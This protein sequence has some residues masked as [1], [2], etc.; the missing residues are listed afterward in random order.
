MAAEPKSDD[1][2]VV[3]GKIAMDDGTSKRDDGSPR[4][5]RTYI[6]NV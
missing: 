2:V 3:L 5:P 1:V 6:I 4:R